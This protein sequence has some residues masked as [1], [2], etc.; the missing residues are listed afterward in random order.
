LKLRHSFGTL[1]NVS[2]RHV[3]TGT[4]QAQVLE[5]CRL[6][7]AEPKGKPPAEIE[8]AGCPPGVPNAAAVR[9]QLERVLASQHFRNSKRSQSLLRFVTETLLQGQKELLREKI[10]GIE[11]FGRDAHYDTAHDAIVRNAAIEVRKRLA[12]Y[13][14]DPGRGDELRIGLPAGSYAPTFTPAGTAEIEAPE[15]PIAA[16][17]EPNAGASRRLKLWLGAGA[18]VLLAAAG[19]LG[20]SYLQTQNFDRFWAPVLRGKET[21][22][23][24]VGQPH[25]L[26]R[27]LGPRQAELDTAFMGPNPP[28]GAAEQLLKRAPIEAG[29]IRWNARNYLYLR[30]ALSMARVVG[31]LQSKGRTYQLRP[32]SDTTYTELRRSPAIVIGGFNSRWALRFGDTMQFVFDHKSIDGKMYNCITNKRDP[33]AMKWAVAVSR[34]NALED[35]YAI[36]TRAVDP[37]TE[38]TVVMAA[39]IEDYGTQAAGEFITDPTYMNTALS[40]APRDW[41]KRNF[42]LVLHTRII[43]DAPGPANVVA[44]Q[45]W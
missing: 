5:C 32:D 21:V 34:T 43:E 19:A 12:Q 33:N 31:L 30:D 36:V 1:H 39:G 45:V 14:L 41:Y 29:E 11:V 24:C 40:G 3:T 6:S 16:V 17:A 10:I 25:R 18:I 28:P 2:E 8:I 13:Y 22:Q 44:M 7:D 23:I 15:H 20:Y 42:Q 37:T 27:F 35:D 38:R 26:Y 9:E 4:V